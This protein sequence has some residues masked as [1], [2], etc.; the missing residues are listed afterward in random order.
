MCDD[1]EFLI[2]SSAGSLENPRDGFRVR[3]FQCAW[4]ASVALR[5]LPIYLAIPYLPKRR[6]G[7]GMMV[8]LYAGQLVN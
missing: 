6:M 7:R 4:K 2:G 3:C 1:D 5:Q 8:S